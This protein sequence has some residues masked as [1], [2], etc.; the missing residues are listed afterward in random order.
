MTSK[1]YDETPEHLW[2]G[3]GPGRNADGT[4]RRDSTHRRSR[5]SEEWAKPRPRATARA[6]RTVRKTYQ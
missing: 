6:T 4:H 1:H 5:G 2:E 3:K